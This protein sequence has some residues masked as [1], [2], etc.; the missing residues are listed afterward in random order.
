MELL[1]IGIRVLKEQVGM[2][3]SLFVWPVRLMDLSMLLLH[4]KVGML[5]IYQKQ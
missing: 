3:F 5:L 1:S 4:L 2:F